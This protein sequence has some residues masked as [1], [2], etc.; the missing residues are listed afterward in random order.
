MVSSTSSRTEPEKLS[1]A[2]A[3]AR[4][5]D[6]QPSPR[7]RPEQYEP[8]PDDG[9]CKR[10]NRHLQRSLSRNVW[11]LAQSPEAAMLSDRIDPISQGGRW[12]GGRCRT[13]LQRYFAAD[14]AAGADQHLSPH[15]RWAH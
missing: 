1:A 6:P 10:P 9:E 11:T 12:T 7:A 5:P 13:I 8:G 14:C 15:R 2:R 3:G 4:P